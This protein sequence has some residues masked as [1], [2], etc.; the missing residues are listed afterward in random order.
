M[1]IGHLPAGYLWTRML[2]SKQFKIEP[3]SGPYNRLMALGLVGSLLPDLDILYFYLIDNRQ[4]LHHGYWTHIPLFW[5]VLF[6]LVLR[7]GVVFKQPSIKPAA[8][9][10]FPNVF[11]HLGLDT[12][13]G[14]V[15]WLAPF[16]SRDFVLFEVP[17]RYN[18]WVWNFVFNWTILFE[19]TIV[20][21]AVVMFLISRRTRGGEK[22]S[23]ERLDQP[24]ATKEVLPS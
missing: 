23:Q 16:F 19:I 6:G 11:I 18:W 15:R 21:A 7:E 20:S 10:F 2:L 17:A 3:V 4:Y 1:F 13:V 22:S 14:K 12:I 5:L 8:V 9:I 24:G